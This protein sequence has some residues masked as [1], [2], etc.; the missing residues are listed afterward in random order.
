MESSKGRIGRHYLAAMVLGTAL[1]AGAGGSAGAG[2]ISGQAIQDISRYCTTCWRNA[3]LPVDRW[4]DCT[5]EVLRR[6]LERLEPDAWKQ[7][8]AQD[9]DER[10]EFVRAIDAVKKRTLRERRAFTLIDGTASSA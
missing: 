3:R 5:Q 7:V 1:A 8:L 4:S 2:E 10:R 6:L 9:S